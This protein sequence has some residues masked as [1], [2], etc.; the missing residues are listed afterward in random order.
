MRRLSANLC[1]R[2]I[3]GVAPV[4]TLLA[5]MLCSTADATPAYGRRYGVSCN[6]CHSPLPPRLNNVGMLFRRLGFRMPDADD[7]GKLIIKAVPAHGIG[8]AASLSA[9]AAFR[10]DQKAEEGT[11]KATLQ[12]GEVELVAGTAIG[13]HLSTQAMFV[14][15]NDDGEIELEDAEAQF[16][17]GSPRHQVT[18]RAGLMQTF[19][20]QKANHGILTHS[21]PLLFDERAVQ[22]VGDFGGFG[23]GAKLIGAETGYLFTRL[24]DGRFSSTAASVAVYNGVNSEG[25]RAIRNTTRGADVLLQAVQLFGQRNTLGAFYYRG[26]VG[27]EPAV[28]VEPEGEPA[29]EPKDRFTRYGLMGNYLLF[30]RLD[31][32]AGAA[33]GK[34]RTE[35]AGGETRMQGLYAELAATLTKPWIGVYRFD[36]VDP[37]RDRGGDTVR[38]HTVSSTFQADDHLYLTAEYRWLR[39]SEEKDGAFVVNARLIY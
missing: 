39:R 25:E 3:V 37:D 6:T 38:A 26:R 10:R 8:D 33:Q 11:N 20:W 23:L 19:F 31:V 22:G 1:R 2:S 27:L 18:A 36:A 34:D 35:P 14:P 16:N 32:V 29:G 17:A 30:R 24:K 28:A 15:W 12:L 5:L 7:E 9:N 13:N 4:L 21:T